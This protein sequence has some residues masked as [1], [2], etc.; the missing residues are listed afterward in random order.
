MGSAETK[1][2]LLHVVYM[3]EFFV[4]TK[5]GITILRAVTDVLSKSGRVEDYVSVSFEVYLSSGMR[6]VPAFKKQ[7]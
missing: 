5:L 6:E 4:R 7:E 2:E 3:T 1:W